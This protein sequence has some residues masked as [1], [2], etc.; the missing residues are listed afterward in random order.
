MTV[1]EKNDVDISKLFHYGDEFVVTGQGTDTSTVFMRLVGDAEINRARIFAIRKSAE[2]R[3]RLRTPD[4]DERIAFIPSL[5]DITKEELIQI[6]VKYALSDFAREAIKEVAMIYPKEPSSDEP[7]EK[8]EQYQEIVDNFE[9]ERNAKAEKL[10]SKK[11]KEYEKELGK[12]SL[13]SLLKKYENYV[14][15]SVCE[16]EMAN[17]FKEMCVV[18]STFKDKKYSIRAFPSYEVFE[19]ITPSIKRQLLDNYS[20]LEISVDNLKK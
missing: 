20:I 14:I 8:H 11:V 6:L 9:K 15:A 13:E 16:Q 19:N 5:E 12:E 7:L 18:F 4:S 2:L 10:V 3:K 17:K 1:I